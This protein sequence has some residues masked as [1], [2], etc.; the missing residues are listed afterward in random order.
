MVEL[1]CSNFIWFLDAKWLNKALRVFKGFLFNHS[2]YLGHLLCYEHLVVQ[3]LQLNKTFYS[4]HEKVI[5]ETLEI[6]CWLQN[7]PKLILGGAAFEKEEK[8]CRKWPLF[9]QQKKSK[10]SDC[11]LRMAFEKCS[12]EAPFASAWENNSLNRSSSGCFFLF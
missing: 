2:F 6:E 10:R 11:S 7:K 12:E 8:S 1:M 4:S 3:F 5:V 9:V